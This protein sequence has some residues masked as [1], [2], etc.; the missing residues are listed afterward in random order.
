M[1]SFAGLVALPWPFDTFVKAT[2]GPYAP[3]GRLDALASTVSLIVTPLVSVTPKVGLAVSQ[4][5]VLIEYLTVPVEALTRYS[6]VEGENGPPC[7]PETAM[8]VEGVTIKDGAAGL[9]AALICA[10]NSVTGRAS[11]VPEATWLV[12]TRMLN[13][14]SSL[15]LKSYVNCRSVSYKAADQQSRHFSS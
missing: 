14:C 15:R 10:N 7:G 5:G 13:I 1:I 4:D 3:G 6:I 2:P 9:C 12:I 11:N 8:L